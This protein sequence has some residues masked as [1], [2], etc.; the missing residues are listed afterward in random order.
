LTVQALALRD[1]L[2]ALGEG[3]GEVAAGEI[4]PQ[5]AG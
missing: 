2:G 1:V 4:E 3:A 5:T